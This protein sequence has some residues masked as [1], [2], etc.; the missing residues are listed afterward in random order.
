MRLRPPCGPTSSSLTVTRSLRFATHSKNAARGARLGFLDALLAQTHAITANFTVLHDR[1]APLFHVSVTLPA[2]RQAGRVAAEIVPAIGSAGRQLSRCA[3]VPEIR[4][5]RASV[6]S[7]SCVGQKISALARWSRGDSNPRPPPCKGGALPT[8]LRPRSRSR[9]SP[10]F[11]GQ[12]CMQAPA[13]GGRAWT[14]TRD[15]GLIRAAL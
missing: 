7:V 2:C 13:G 10:P 11:S 3:P 5:I 6:E 14:R 8:K 12:A 15:L 9:A 4:M 1:L